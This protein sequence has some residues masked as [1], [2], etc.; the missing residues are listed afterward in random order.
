MENGTNLRNI[1][2]NKTEIIIDALIP[3]TNYII[4]VAAYSSSGQG[5]WSSEFVVKTL[6]HNVSVLWGNAQYILISDIMGDYIES[7]SLDKNEVSIY[8]MF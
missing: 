3:S 5:P 7:F 2:I 4:K 6:N 8:N 1:D